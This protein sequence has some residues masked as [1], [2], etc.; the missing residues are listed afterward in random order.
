MLNQD[1]YARPSA[2]DLD[3]HPWMG[4]ENEEE[5]SIDVS[6]LMIDNS[7]VEKVAALGYPSDFVTN[8]LRLREV[9]QATASYFL[10]SK[11]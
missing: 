3:L 7:I 11:S 1:P 10:F 5:K 6:R 2:F 8:S 4:G 9:N